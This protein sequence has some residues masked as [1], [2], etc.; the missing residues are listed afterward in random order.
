MSVYLFLHLVNDLQLSFRWFPL[1]FIAVSFVFFWLLNEFHFVTIFW[2][3]CRDRNSA[4]CHIR[5]SLTSCIGAGHIIFYAGIDSTGN[6]VTLWTPT[7]VL[8]SWCCCSSDLLVYLFVC[9]LIDLASSW[10]KYWLF[11]GYFCFF[12]FFVGIFSTYVA[13]FVCFLTIFVLFCLVL[14]LSVFWITIL[15]N[16]I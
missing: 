2:L 12:F 13:I 3:I 10:F 9:F 5:V 14:F 15:K 1:P 6:Q 7:F 4:L 16:T 8:F 11:F